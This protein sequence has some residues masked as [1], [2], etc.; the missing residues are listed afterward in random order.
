MKLD[1]FIAGLLGGALMHYTSS[2]PCMNCLYL[3][4]H[5]TSI[6]QSTAIDLDIFH[7][8]DRFVLVLLRHPP[9]RL[10][11]TVCLHF[12]CAF[13][14][15]FASYFSLDGHAH[16]SFRFCLLSYTLYF[17]CILVHFSLA[18][19]MFDLWGVTSGEKFGSVYFH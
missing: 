13:S 2:A 5:D 11:F 12:R 7:L 10:R 16:L 4:S 9:V 6:K 17:C 8:C 19:P 3:C 18:T 14:W 1:G 15:R